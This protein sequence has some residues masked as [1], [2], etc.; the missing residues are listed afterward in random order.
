[1][2]IN[3]HRIKINKAADTIKKILPVIPQTCV[4]T[5]SG[6]SSLGDIL[7]D[8]KQIPYSEIPGFPK[9]TV[10]G[11]DGNLLFG[12]IKKNPVLILVGRSHYYEGNSIEDVVFPIR[13]LSQLGI[14]TLILTNAAGGVNKSFS[15]GELMVIKDHLGFFCPSPLRGENFDEYGP[16]FPD[17]SKIY[18]CEE[19]LQASSDIDIKVNTGVYC[20]SKGPMFETPAEIKAISKMGGDA[21]GMSTVPEAIVASHAGMKVIGISTITNY[22]AGITKQPLSHEEVLEVGKKASES[23]KEIIINIVLQ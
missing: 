9:S 14:K 11:H 16:R 21:V 13:V 10:K 6:L 7:E 22:A 1:M 2:N 17:Q 12:F 19:A 23:L 18:S 8:K 3:E 5:G 15:P 20:Y 4:V